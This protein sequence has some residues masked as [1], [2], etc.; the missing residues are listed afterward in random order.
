MRMILDERSSR[1]PYIAS[2][3]GP[4]WGP[5]GADMTQIG[6]ML[7]TWTL[8]YGTI[9]QFSV[10]AC[11]IQFC[12]GWQESITVLTRDTRKSLRVGVSAVKF[13]QLV[14][15]SLF[16]IYM[17]CGIYTWW[18]SRLLHKIKRYKFQVYCS[19]CLSL[20]KPETGMK[21]TKHERSIYPGPYWYW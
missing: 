20:F 5:S 7:A 8:L 10:F 4:T 11:F 6:L 3:M 18:N 21:C 17:Y 9:S 14:L 1:I 2:F 16:F 15:L 13:H 12:W 19:V